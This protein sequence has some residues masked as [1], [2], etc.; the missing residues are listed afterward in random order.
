MNFEALSLS[1][2]ANERQ[3]TN[4][5][6]DMIP[7]KKARN[8]QLTI[9]RFLVAATIP[10]STASNKCPPPNPINVSIATI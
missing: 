8:I 3:Q 10:E 5:I 2:I 1:P 9:L 4:T 7:Q 6:K